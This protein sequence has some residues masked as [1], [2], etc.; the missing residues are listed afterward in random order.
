MGWWIIIWIQS[1]HEAQISLVI[2]TV[3]PLG[4]YSWEM[5]S[6]GQAGSLEC[7]VGKVI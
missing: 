7:S 2:Q 4:L 3:V 5:D 1:P 6:M